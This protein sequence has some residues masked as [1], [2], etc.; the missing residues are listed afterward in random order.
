M[1]VSSPEVSAAQ[2]GS[3]AWQD[4]KHLKHGVEST[5]RRAHAPAGCRVSRGLSRA[6]QDAKRREIMMPSS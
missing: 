2:T 5:R 3:R 1:I 6:R 4:A